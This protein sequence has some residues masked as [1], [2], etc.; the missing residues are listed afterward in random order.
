MSVDR[1]QANC[2]EAAVVEAVLPRTE[3]ASQRRVQSRPEAV[4][5]DAVEEEV[6]AERDVERQVADGF[7]YLHETLTTENKHVI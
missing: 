1:R 6:R 2:A 3:T 5:R 7:R 4:A